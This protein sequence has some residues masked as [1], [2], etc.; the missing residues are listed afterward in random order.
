MMWSCMSIWEDTASS[1]QGRVQKI[2]EGQIALLSRR[3]RVHRGGYGV[4]ANGLGVT[5][6]QRL[7]TFSRADPT[8]SINH[9]ISFIK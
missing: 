6:T 3:F 4:G 1:V 5:G 8:Y 7:K 9:S 2:R